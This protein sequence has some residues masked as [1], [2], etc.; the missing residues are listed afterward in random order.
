MVTLLR[1]NLKCLFRESEL[2]VLPSLVLNK[3]VLVAST[4]WINRATFE[5]KVMP[6]LA[7][8]FIKATPNF[9]FIKICYTKVVG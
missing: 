3:M 2:Y 5:I 7:L 8:A 1:N 4:V 6:I 9:D